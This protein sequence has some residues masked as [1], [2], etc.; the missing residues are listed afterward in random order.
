[1]AQRTFDCVAFDAIVEK[2][3]SPGSMPPSTCTLFKHGAEQKNAARLCE[4][5]SDNLIVL[6]DLKV[7]D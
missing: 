2:N 4:L 6:F 7:N 1:M 5:L 3:L